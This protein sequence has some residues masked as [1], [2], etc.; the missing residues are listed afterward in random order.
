MKILLASTS[1]LALPTLELLEKSSHQ[2]LGILTKPEKPSGRGMESKAQELVSEL[3]GL[4]QI[5]T[6]ANQEELAETLR[7]VKADL[8]V[9]ISF[10]M[11]VKQESLVLPKHGWI[12]LHFSLLPKF[13]GAAPVQRAIL[14]GENSSGV[15]V[16]ALDEGMDTGAIYS[17]RELPI[18]DM[19]SGAALEVMARIG[20]EA[21]LEAIELISKN[22]Q[23]IA[24]SGEPTLAKKI[25]PEE[26][27]ISFDCK[28][29][30]IERQIRAFAPKPGAWA[31]FKGNRVKFLAAQ[32]R[33]GASG[34]IG[35]V[36]NVSPLLVAAKDGA[37]LIG[38]LQEAGKRI[39]TSEEWARGVRLQVGEKFE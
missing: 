15:T 13:R 23:P 27:R 7:R 11:L 35:E 16:F 2:I 18:A 12:N 4:H 17:T 20:S 3:D 30:Q 33:R 37:L 5:F 14:A 34:S 8:V 19:N 32:V 28:V 22:S 31:M 21:V 9:A 1:R 26:L 29:E 10:G 38:S 36:I 24:Q 6:V 39:M 25:S